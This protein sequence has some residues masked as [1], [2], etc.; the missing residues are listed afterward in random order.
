M[1]AVLT[2]FTSS[3]TLQVTPQRAFCLLAVL[4]GAVLSGS[5]RAQDGLVG[6]SIITVEGDTLV[7]L[8]ESDPWIASEVGLR[9]REA[10]REEVLV[11]PHSDVDAVIVGEN[12]YLRRVVSVDLAPLRARLR[13]EE[14]PQGARRDSVYLA[15]LVR[16][17][18]SLYS[19]YDTRPHYYVGEGEQ[20]TELVARERVVRRGG[21]FSVVR[22]ETFN[23]QLRA[24][25]PRCPEAHFPARGLAYEGDA[26]AAFVAA[27]GRGE[28][29]GYEAPER[30]FAIRHGF[31]IGV[32]LIP[33]AESPWPVQNY[34]G[35]T[36]AAYK[37]EYVAEIGRRGRP[38]E[39]V[40]VG[41]ALRQIR[42]TGTKGRPQT[43]HTP[44]CSTCDYQRHV[45]VP[46][47]RLRSTEVAVSV[48]GRF[49]VELGRTQPFLEGGGALSAPVHF[50]GDNA[51]IGDTYALEP[52]IG[53]AVERPLGDRVG[54]Y[55][56]SESA[57][58]AGSGIYASF[59]G[60]AGVAVDRFRF[61]VR[62]EQPMGLLLMKDYEPS[63]PS[64]YPSDFEPAFIPGRM[65]QL[66]L[67]YRP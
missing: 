54:A 28:V 55:E 45:V 38:Q 13:R 14:S 7:G 64:N 19:Y 24:L 21:R 53:P 62:L 1:L 6:G 9:F 41:V 4:A 40:R 23:E 37:I 33:Q 35:F 42:H 31:D 56:S 66:S 11:V 8:V 59:I 50:V 61:G 22:E 63:P 17:P 49:G 18:I 15:A 2:A 44:S 10:R 5:A 25:Q 67:G 16:G 12:T 46:E 51:L 65:Y 29:E 57:W 30:P 52:G 47:Q 48:T 32:S 39:S 26:L 60:G 20:L 43:L 27:C 34:G 36:S 3:T 58:E